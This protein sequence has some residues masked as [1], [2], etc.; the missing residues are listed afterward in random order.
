MSF[1][2]LVGLGMLFGIGFGYFVQRS[3]LCFAHGLG[4]IYL[5]KGKRIL[6][7][8]LVIFIIT[9]IGFVAS[10]YF[11]PNLGLKPIGQLRGFGF[12]N[13]LSGMLFGAGIALTGGCILGT[14]RQIGEGNLTFVIVLLCFIPGMWLVVHVLNPALEG[15]YN[16]QKVLL[17]GLLGVSAP[18]VTAVL[19]TAAVVG[20]VVVR[21]R[22]RRQK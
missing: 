20:L 9:S 18:Y 21:R 1:G 8:F 6:R 15:G 5:G 16:V 22:P 14:L 4:E 2:V 11:S 3:G 13:L 17:P 12:Y 19:A 7:F 10:S